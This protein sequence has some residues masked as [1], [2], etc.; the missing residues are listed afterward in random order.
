MPSVHDDTRGSR[1]GMPTQ[2]PA[3]RKLFSQNRHADQAQDNEQGQ[4]PENAPFEGSHREE[5]AA[6]I[7]RGG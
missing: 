7:A 3:R 5:H 1:A 4:A 2:P 6:I